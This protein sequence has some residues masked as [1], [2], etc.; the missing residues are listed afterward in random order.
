MTSHDADVMIVGAGLVGRTLGVALKAAQPDLAV[1][2]V[3]PAAGAKRPPD[4]RASAIAAT[5]RRML[6]RLGVWPDIAEAAEP[7]LEMAITDSSLRD[8]VRPPR[9]VFA[10]E[11][12]EG[13]P[14]AHM[15]PNTDLAAALE[16]RLAELGVATERGRVVLFG[17][18]PAA[19]RVTL[20]GGGERMVRLL[21][22]ADG[23][24]SWL[25]AL[26]G[27]D[28]VG[29]RYEQCGIVTNVRHEHPHRG[30]AVQHFLPSG[31]FA[32][33]P[34]R[35]KRCSIVW[36]ERREVAERLA[37]FDD[38]SFEL[39]L[40]R[41]FGVELGRIEVDGARHVY[42]LELAIARRYVADR[43][44]LVGDAAHTIH[45]LAGQGLNLGLRDVAALA[46]VV[47]TTHRL[48]LDIGG[49]TAL[50]RYERWRRA[51]VVAMGVATDL[52]NA[53]FS[54]DSELMR[55]ARGLGLGLVDRAG[56]LKR[57]FVREA[58]GLEGDLPRLMR[59]EIV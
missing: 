3:D 25:R 57:F 32:I 34:L 21:V 17:A 12:G 2:L 49:A 16:R 55:L 52:F 11:T 1:M 13:E 24:R 40:E 36:T 35:G 22:A 54:N 18:E 37:A 58:A 28:T 30:R 4:D 7:I 48:G 38:Y 20:A 29:R 46:E 53:V 23:A 19:M 26:A 5:G 59:G 47:A 50:E 31:P 15:V 10:D 45:P 27:I 6:M 43:F 42:P 56:A 9:L 8:V 33:L 39:E 41:R 44:A 51:D 14:F